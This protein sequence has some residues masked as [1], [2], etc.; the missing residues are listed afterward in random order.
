MSFDADIVVV[1]AGP[2]GLAFCRSLVQSPVSIIVIE[3]QAQ[4]QIAH[5]PFDGREIALTHASRHAMQ[6]LGIWERVPKDEI[7]LLRDAK[8]FDG[9]SDYQLHFPKPADSPEDEGL[10]YFIANHNIRQASY[11][12]VSTQENVD[13]RYG[14]GVDDVALNPQGATVTL[15]DG[16]SIK[17][18]L[19]VAADSR[20]SSTRRKMGIGADWNDYG[21]SVFVFRMQHTISNEHS[22]YECFHY[23]RTLAILPLEEHLCSCVVTIDT[24]RAH[25][26]ADLNP[27]QLAQA[28]MEQLKNRL[29]EMTLVER[30]VTYPLV[31]VHAKRFYGLSCAVIGDAAVGMHP[32]TAHGYNL[33]LQSAVILGQLIHDAAHA[34][35]DIAAPSL[36]AK[37]QTKHM[38]STRTIY[39]G[40]NFVVKLFTTETPPAKLLRKAVMRISNNFPPV[41]FLISRQLTRISHR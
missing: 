37:Y 10:G 31:G 32:V 1:G 24:H 18:R 7:Y 20:F 29:G 27:E 16:S 8:V 21:R 26:I 23:G 12:A 11:D 40:T 9:T 3:K 33:G 13:I 15:E 30:V 2:A 22:A 4:E 14:H 38:L 19:V 6:K 28:T 36:L 34:G 25:E 5:P 41:K 17:C 35:Q 39:H